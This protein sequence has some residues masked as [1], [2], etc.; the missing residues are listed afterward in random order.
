MH[1]QCLHWERTLGSFCRVF[2]RLCPCAI[3]L[4]SFTYLALYPFIVINLSHACNYMLSPMC[5]FSKSPN[6]EV[7]SGIDPPAQGI[8]RWCVHKPR[9]WSRAELGSTVP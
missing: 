2:S 7:V 3:T 1:I 9:M 4:Q 6:I 5:L 8:A